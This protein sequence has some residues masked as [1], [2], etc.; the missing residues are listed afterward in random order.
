ML[1]SYGVNSN[2]DE[3]RL[4]TMDILNQQITVVPFVAFNMFAYAQLTSGNMDIQ[5]HHE[6]WAS[7]AVTGGKMTVYDVNQF[8]SAVI[9]S[10]VFSQTGTRVPASKRSERTL[11]NHGVEWREKQGLECERFLE[12][13]R[14]EIGEEQ[15]GFLEEDITEAMKRL[16]AGYTIKGL[17]E[18]MASGTSPCVKVTRGRFQGSVTRQQSCVAQSDFTWNN[19]VFNSTSIKVYTSS[20]MTTASTSYYV[21]EDYPPLLGKRSSRSTH[22]SQPKRRAQ[23]SPVWT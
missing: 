13:V 11:K 16:R 8:D 2:D 15:A 5:S 23:A 19:D 17:L 18:W 21:Q 22:P 4:N 3:Y 14:D 20:T 7:W 1:D 10:W 12:S 9:T 6:A